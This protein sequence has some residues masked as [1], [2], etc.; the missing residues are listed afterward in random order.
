AARGRAEWALIRRMNKS[1]EGPVDALINWRFSMRITRVLARRSL[2]VTPNHVTVVAIVVGLVASWLASR[3]GYGMF[4]VGG[5]QLDP[6]FVRRGA[7]A[8]AVSVL[9]ARAVARQPVG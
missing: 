8:A 6:G 5:V 2:A 9:A 1:F 7:G 4:A 3:G